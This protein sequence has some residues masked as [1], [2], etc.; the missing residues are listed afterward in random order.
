MLISFALT[1]GSNCL[2][3]ESSYREVSKILKDTNY[4]AIGLIGAFTTFILHTKANKIVHL[5]AIINFLM[6]N[7]LERPSMEPETIRRSNKIYLLISSL[8]T[9]SQLLSLFMALPFIIMFSHSGECYF[10]SIFYN[11]P[12]W[13]FWAHVNNWLFILQLWWI[14]LSCAAFLLILIEMVI[15]IT[16]LLSVTASE[17]L[18]LRSKSDCD[19]EEECKKFKDIFKEINLLNWCVGEINDIMASYLIVY[20]STI[21]VI[22]AVFLALMLTIKMDQELVE[23]IILFIYM[24]GFFCTYCVIGQ[25]FTDSVSNW[26]LLIKIKILLKWEIVNPVWRDKD[27]HLRLRLV[28][29]INAL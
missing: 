23:F 22:S 13:S 18:Q 12:P 26:E 19:E 1:C 16:F 4:S 5:C 29:C 24:V 9:I 28:L 27:R 25:H 6:K 17:I 8:S 3:S 11:V 21:F 7:V 10:K 2:R 15:R 14:G 20:V